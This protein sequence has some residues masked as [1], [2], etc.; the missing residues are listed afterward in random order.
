MIRLIKAIWNI[1][2]WIWKEILW[3]L[4]YAWGEALALR[5]SEEILLK[6]RDEEINVHLST[7]A[8]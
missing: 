4:T 8:P 3:S 1:D 7:G 2:D 6:Q 5:D